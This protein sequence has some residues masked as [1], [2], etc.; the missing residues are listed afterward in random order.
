MNHR[1]YVLILAFTVSLLLSPYVLADEPPLPRESKPA[2]IG[3]PNPALK[4]IGTVVFA[5]KTPEAESDRAGLWNTLQKAVTNQLSRADISWHIP[6]SG[7]AG[8]VDLP[9][10]TLAV[11]MLKPDDSQQYVF[12][13]Q[14]SLSAVVCLKDD[15]SVCLKAE[16]WKISS[17]MQAVSEKNL[18]AT[19]IEE[20]LKQAESFTLAYS[21]ANQAKTEESVRYVA[22]KKSK[23]FHK[24]DCLWAKRISPENLIKFTS[25]E[26]AVKAGCRPCKRCEP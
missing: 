24:P 21:A 8:P 1:R 18:S 16:L 12:R 10:F 23:I 7:A 4:G 2:L 15:S 19:I 9:V 11:D 3:R 6:P 22:S 26:E 13:L 25:R 14:T 17:Q 20:A 5:L